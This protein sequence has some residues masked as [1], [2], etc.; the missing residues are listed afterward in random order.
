[1]AITETNTSMGVVT[2]KQYYTKSGL[3]YDD[4]FWEAVKT[5]ENLNDALKASEQVRPFKKEADYSYVFKEVSGDS[6]VLV[7][8]AAR[9]VDPI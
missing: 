8:D 3:S 7:G 5:R 6:F 4:F 1:I 2:Q 9:F